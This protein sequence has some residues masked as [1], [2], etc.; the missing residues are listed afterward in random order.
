MQISFH[1]Q[2]EQKEPKGSSSNPHPNIRW[3][4]HRAP[5]ANQSFYIDGIFEGTVDC[6]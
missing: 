6:L 4:D 2:K 5:N 1:K 3:F